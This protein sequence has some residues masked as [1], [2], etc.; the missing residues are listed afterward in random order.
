MSTIPATSTPV[1]P[2]PNSTTALM[3]TARAAR[4]RPASR[5]TI[6]HP[7]PRTS[8]RHNPSSPRTTYCRRSIRKRSAAPALS[9]PVMVRVADTST[10]TV[11]SLPGGRDTTRATGR[12]QDA[13]TPGA[14]S[15]GA[16]SG[17]AVNCAHPSVVITA[18]MPAARASGFR[19]GSMGHQAAIQ[20]T[21]AASGDVRS[22]AG[23]ALWC[24]FSRDGQGGRV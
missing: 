15:A 8:T 7:P 12:S 20:D 4:P 21:A 16:C 22:T 3:P 5:R 18:R 1:P 11:V 10:T 6:S 19:C 13:V 17:V 14:V 9:G 23:A 24:R 2:P